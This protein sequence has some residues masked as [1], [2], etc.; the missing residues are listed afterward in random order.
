MDIHIN[1]LEKIVA[2]DKESRMYDIIIEGFSEDT[3]LEVCVL[4]K[5]LLII[6]T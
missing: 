3:K 5:Y 6:I 1:L 2:A 4:F